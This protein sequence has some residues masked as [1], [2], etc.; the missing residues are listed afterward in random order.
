MN[1]SRTSPVVHFRRRCVAAFL[2]LLLFPSASGGASETTTE[3]ELVIASGQE[4]LLANMLGRGAAFPGPC[5]FTGAKA[6]PKAIQSTYKCPAGE[7]ELELSHPSKAPASAVRTSRFAIAVLKGSPPADFSAAREA[8]IRTHETTFQWQ[9]LAPKPAP[10]PPPSE[11]QTPE[12]QDERS[13][14]ADAFTVVALVA[15]AALAFALFWPTIR[16]VSRPAVQALQRDRELRWVIVIFLVSALARGWVCVINWQANDDHFFVAHLIREAGWSPPASSACMECSHPKLYHYLLAVASEIVGG[17]AA[18]RKAGNVLNGI[19]ATILFAVLYAYSRRA[20]CSSTVRLL[21]IGLFSFTAALVGIFSQATNDGFCILFSSLAIYSM[22]RFLVDFRFRQM[23][24]AT[25]FAVLAAASKASGWAIFGAGALVV[26]GKLL[27]TDSSL[28]RRLIVPALAYVVGFLL[29]VSLINPYRQN[30]AERGTPFVNDAFDL[31][32]VRIEVPRPPVAWVFENFLTF[33]FLELLRSPYIEL[34]RPTDPP[35]HRESLWSQ[36]YGRTFFL[37]F[38]RGIWTPSDPGVFNLGRLCLVLGL[39]PL[40]A[41]LIGTG[42]RLRSVWRGLSSR[43]LRWLAY[44]DEWHHLV[45][46]GV[47]L[48]AFVALIVAYHRTA[49]LSVWMKAIYLL[50]AILPFF[51]LFLH[52]LQQLWQRHPRFVTLWMLAM[53]AASIVDLGWLIHDLMPLRNG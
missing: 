30:I 50:P 18:T 16:S 37:R 42:D 17:D 12:G 1:G 43:G 10:P 45:Y 34:G 5:E 8:R 44:A 20:S 51:A 48:S 23:L 36:V 7:V 9:S 46:A 21:A 47:M 25:A 2:F 32:M 22:D 52:G 40:A 27:A 11:S 19:A 26:F 6:S 49:I 4:E 24:A 31:P 39:L 28:R 33:R 15:I 35:A 53:I 41:L 38:D 13:L 14:A 3:D 29:V